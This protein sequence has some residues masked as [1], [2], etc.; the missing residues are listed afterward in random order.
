MCSDKIAQ[1]G[2]GFRIVEVSSAQ[3]NSSNQL[4]L[5]NKYVLTYSASRY[6]ITQYMQ[7][8]Q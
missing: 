8:L 6:I 4:L 5:R 2:F 3:I 1:T 7:I